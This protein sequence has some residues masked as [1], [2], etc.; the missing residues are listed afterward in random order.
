MP[1]I[2]SNVRYGCGATV[3]LAGVEAIKTRTK[4]TQACQN[5]GT[6]SIIKILHGCNFKEPNGREHL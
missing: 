4:T 5:F 3:K 2:F 1:G 6:L